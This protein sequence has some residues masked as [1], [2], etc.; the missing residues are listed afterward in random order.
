MGAAERRAAAGGELRFKKM[1]V[2]FF[3]FCF[4][5]FL[6]LVTFFVEVVCRMIQ[7]IDADWDDAEG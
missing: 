2:S 4:V 7:M 3:V 5:S 1:H 6:F